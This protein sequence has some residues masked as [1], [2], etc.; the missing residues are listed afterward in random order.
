MSLARLIIIAFTLAPCVL[1]ADIAI[2]ARNIRPGDVMNITDVMVIRGTSEGAFESAEQIIGAEAKVAL[3]AGRAILVGQITPAAR[4]QRNQIIE[5]NF[6]SSGL[7]MS[8]EGRALS[9]GTV[10]QRIRVMNLASKTSIFGIV[11][12]DGSVSVSE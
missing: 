5:I 8:T 10:G 6:S 2:A 11:Q 1:S 9:R 7:S 3:Y 12:Q 4:V